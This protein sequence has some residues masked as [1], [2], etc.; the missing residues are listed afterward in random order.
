M[1]IDWGDAPAW[2]AFGIS[3]ISAGISAGSVIYARS[4]ARST[5][6]AAKA[7]VRQAAAAEEQTTI[8]RRTLELAE[9]QVPASAGSAFM[10]QIEKVLTQET[11][12][13]VAWWID[14]SSKNTYILR[15]IGT[16]TARDV[17]ID[18]SRIRCVVR[19]TTKAD[20]VA[21]HA[22]VEIL[23]IPMWGAPKPNEL[24]VRWDGHPEWQAVQVP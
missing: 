14:H 1:G 2:A 24:W 20:E 11:P 22:S 4:S 23:L 18:Q 7:A 6:V 5:E 21:P 3:I 9:Q 15:N 10:Q 12:P 13:Y 16:G 17:E 19:G 8:A